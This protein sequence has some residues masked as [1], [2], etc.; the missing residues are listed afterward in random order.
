MRSNRLLE[1]LRSLETEELTKRA[2]DVLNEEH[3]TVEH[4]VAR[5]LDLPDNKLSVAATA[6]LSARS[7]VNPSIDTPHSS[8]V[9]LNDMQMTYGASFLYQVISDVAIRSTRANPDL[10]DELNGINI[11]KLFRKVAA[12]PILG[13]SRLQADFHPLAAETLPSITSF[14][15]E[16]PRHIK[17]HGG[18]EPFTTNAGRGAL[19]GVVALAEYTR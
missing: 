19:M 1:G 14:A 11:V 15:D 7:I 4:A 5:C 8:D 18:S 2:L 10:W 6:V 3:H 13:E 16:V 9:S 17:Q 12:L